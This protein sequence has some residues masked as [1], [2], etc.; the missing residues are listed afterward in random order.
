MS[1][2]KTENSMGQ[3]TGGSKLL[4][5]IGQLMAIVMFV[6]VLIM[7]LLSG[8]ASGSAQVDG[9]AADGSASS[10]QVEPAEQPG[11]ETEQTVDGEKSGGFVAEDSATVSVDIS[12]NKGEA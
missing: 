4:A 1:A 5:R 7:T 2:T 12:S 8:C 11:T 3:T 9:Q 6:T 10:A